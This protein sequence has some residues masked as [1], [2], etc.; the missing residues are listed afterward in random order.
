MLAFLPPLPILPNPSTSLNICY[1]NRR[2]STRWRMTKSSPSS[3]PPTTEP[4]PPIPRHFPEP[5]PDALYNIFSQRLS[6]TE[7]LDFLPENVQWNTPL[8]DCSSKDEII[9][10]LET[11]LS[12]VIEPTITIYT[13]NQTSFSWTVSYVHPLPWRPRV[14]IAGETTFDTTAPSVI[15]DTWFVSTI[16]PFQ[17][18]LPT[19]VDILWLFPAPH[20]ETDRGQRRTLKR[21]D[22]YDV[23][24]FAEMTEMRFLVPPIRGLSQLIYCA[25]ALPE[26]A[27]PGLLAKREKYFATRPIGVRLLDR[28]NKGDVELSVPVPGAMLGSSTVGIDLPECASLKV[29]DRRIMAIRRFSEV[30]MAD[31]VAE[32]VDKVLEDLQRDGVDVGWDRVWVRNYDSKVGFNRDGELAMSMFGSSFGV[33]RVTEIAVDITDRSEHRKEKE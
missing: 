5:L 27:S 21:C 25:P 12:F 3:I 4:T 16:N 23:V 1:S 17:Q 19:L 2:P 7:A 9:D 26:E 8:F 6:P 28:E 14:T 31:L 13:I 32:K 30:P 22:G 24:E 20:A 29:L 11:F 10:Q 33:P 15:T 18:I